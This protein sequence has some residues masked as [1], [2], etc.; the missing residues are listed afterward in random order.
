VIRAAVPGHRPPGYTRDPS[1]PVI[2]IDNFPPYANPGD[3]AMSIGKRGQQY[4]W[5]ARHPGL[6]ALTGLP[7]KDIQILTA[8]GDD[9]FAYLPADGT[10][11][12]LLRDQLLKVHGVTIYVSVGL[13]KPLPAMIRTW[14]RTHQHEDLQA[15]LAALETALASRQQKS[16]MPYG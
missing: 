16:L 4:A 1:R 14:T 11:P 15:S 7:I 5:H 9:W 13:P 10:P 2:I 12:Q 6:G 3:I 8:T